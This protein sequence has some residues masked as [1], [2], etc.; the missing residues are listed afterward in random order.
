MINPDLE[1]YSGHSAYLDID[2]KNTNIILHN[3]SLFGLWIDLLIDLL[4]VLGQ[5][6][7]QEEAGPD[8]E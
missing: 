1:I 4:L 3:I 5:P 2:L 8:D 7:G 6:A